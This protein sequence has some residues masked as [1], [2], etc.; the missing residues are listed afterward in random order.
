L[1]RHQSDARLIAIHAM[2]T[3]PGGR[4]SWQQLRTHGCGTP[5]S[6]EFPSARL[7]LQWPKGETMVRLKPGPRAALGEKVLDFAH[8]A[9]LLWS[10][11]SS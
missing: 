5:V 6:S 9:G 2:V 4:F 3:T 10:L 11:D 1:H 8:L 7:S